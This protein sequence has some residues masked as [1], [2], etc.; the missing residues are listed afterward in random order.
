MYC[1][2]RKKPNCIIECK[3]RLKVVVTK[4]SL[5]NVKKNIMEESNII[6]L[7]ISS[8]L[9]TFILIFA[10]GINVHSNSFFERGGLE[11]HN[12]FVNNFIIRLGFI[13]FSEEVY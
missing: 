12:L 3:I 4:S 7:Y 13:E 9:A 1:D 10:L 5:E 6:L 2:L 11:D 8:S